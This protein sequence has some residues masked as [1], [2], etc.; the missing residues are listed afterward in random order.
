MEDNQ[1]S[2]PG[3]VQAAKLNAS[4]KGLDSHNVTKRFVIAHTRRSILPS[5]ILTASQLANGAHAAH[6]L[7][8]PGHLRLPFSRRQ[9]ALVDRHHRRPRCYTIRWLDPQAQLRFPGKLPIR[10]ADCALQDPHLPPQR[11]LF[12][13]HLLGYPQGQVDGG[14][15]Y[16]DGLAESAEPPRRTQQVSCPIFFCLSLF[17]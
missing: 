6:D 1:N 3:S 8:R 10:T 2:A 12:R 9:P 13:P 17:P 16:P 15:Q 5:D 14:I 4:R 11:R 7:A